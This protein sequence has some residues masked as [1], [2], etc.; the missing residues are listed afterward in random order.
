M[1]TCPR[2]PKSRH[3]RGKSHATSVRE[4][5]MF[6]QETKRHGADRR[7]QRAVLGRGKWG[8]KKEG[9]WGRRKVE[10]GKEGG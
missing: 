10:W 5:H 3:P 8:K 6:Y 1:I 7:P 4:S 9:A 2:A